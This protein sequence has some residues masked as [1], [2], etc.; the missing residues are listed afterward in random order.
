M[1]SIYDQYDSDPVGYDSD[2]VFDS[3]SD[4][5]PDNEPASDAGDTS[6]NAPDP[7]NEII[8]NSYEQLDNESQEWDPLV[9]SDPTNEKIEKS[10]EQVVAELQGFHPSVSKS[11][12]QYLYPSKKKH[13]VQCKRELLY[14]A[15]LDLY[16]YYNGRI[17]TV[18]EMARDAGREGVCFQRRGPSTS[19]CLCCKSK[20]PG[21]ETYAFTLVDMWWRP[22]ELVRPELTFSI[23]DACLSYFLNYP[24]HNNMDRWADGDLAVEKCLAFR[25]TIPGLPR[26]LCLQILFW[27]AY[28]G[29]RYSY[30]RDT[31]VI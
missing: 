7:T 31:S 28:A 25:S 20:K 2:Y 3:D 18:K 10:Y 26:E 14:A 4:S 13:Y 11:I 9:P 22:A 21:R 1:D 16:V 23:D 17:P 6:N 30:F 29:L 19:I 8:R 24:W 5:A 15:Y 12:L 27:G